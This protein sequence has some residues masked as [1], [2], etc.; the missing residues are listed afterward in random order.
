VDELYPR[1][2]SSQ[3]SSRWSCPLRRLSF[4]SKVDKAFSPLVPSPSR[5]ARLFGGPEHNMIHGTRSHPTQLF[6]SLYDKL[7]NV[8]TSNG[9]C[10]CVSWKD[11][12]VASNIATA[13]KNCTL[14]ETIRSMY[15]GKYR[16][17]QLLASASDSVCTQQLDWP[18]V[19]G[20]M[21]DGSLSTA[22]YPSSQVP[23]ETTSGTCNVLDRIPPFQYRYMPVGKVAKPA[24]GKDSLSDGGSCH[25]GRGARMPPSSSFSRS[26]RMCRK[27]YTNH[28]HIV[29]RC[30]FGTGSS[31]YTVR[32]FFFGVCTLN[33]EG[34][35][36]TDEVCFC[37]GSGDDP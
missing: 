19:G 16:T 22:R 6:E 31:T 36:R 14:L 25:M 12:Q 15:D 17:T 3:H 21:R 2:A 8:V 37:P 5:S 18:F 26:T 10:F 29:A 32:G 20:L 13:A 28:T 7:A 30:F 24:D 27:I 23:T 33:M 9:F 11:C 34:P 35:L 1:Q 4:W